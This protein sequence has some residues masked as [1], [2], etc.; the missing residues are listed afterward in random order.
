[1]KNAVNIS[2]IQERAKLSART[3][4][5]AVR[6]LRINFHLPIASWKHSTDGGYYLIVDDA[7][8][9]AWV[10]DVT[11]QVRA[12]VAVLRAAAGPKAGLELLGQLQIELTADSEEATHA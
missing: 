11:D 10:K 1:M 5:G 12:E 9:A 7:D 8:R 3:I 4:K 6:S 2:E